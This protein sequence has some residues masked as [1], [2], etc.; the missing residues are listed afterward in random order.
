MTLSHPNVLKLLDFNVQNESKEVWM[1]FDYIP[2]N[3]GKYYIE[4]KDPKIFTEN[5]FKNIAYQIINGVFYLHKNL[6]IHR[7]LKPENILYNDS[8]NLIQIADFGLSRKISFDLYEKYTNVGT[9]PYKPPDVLLGNQYYGFSFDVW[10][11]ACILVEL[12]TG[13][14]LFPANDSLSIL[15]LM[16][17][18]FGIFNKNDLPFCEKLN[19]FNKMNFN[20]NNLNKKPFGIINYIKKYSMIEFENDYFFDLIQK[21]FI[22]DPNKR[23][24]LKDCLKHPWFENLL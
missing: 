20:D 1:L 24:K 15:K 8:K 2:T 3:I 17:E 13:K 10:S 18:I 5:F 14:I 6:I 19:F 4:K 16:F 7:D 23:I 12:I 22:I 9:L 21:M 11:I